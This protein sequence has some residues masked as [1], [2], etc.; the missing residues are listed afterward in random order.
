[1]LL[2]ACLHAIDGKEKYTI[3]GVIDDFVYN[4]MYAPACT[5]YPVFRYLQRELFNGAFK[6][7]CNLKNAVAKVQGVIKSNNPGYPVE[8]SFCG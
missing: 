1:M 8:F 3:V 2:E 7:G 6:T 5:A 4:S